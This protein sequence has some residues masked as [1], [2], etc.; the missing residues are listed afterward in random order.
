MKLKPKGV[1]FSFFTAP[2]RLAVADPLSGRLL[3]LTPPL[4]ACIIIV[5][6]IRSGVV[7]P[8]PGGGVVG[9]G[10]GGLQ[11]NLALATLL[12]QSLCFLASL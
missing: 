9:G 11:A 8:D 12:R 5:C 1:V 3:I 4:H 10:R 7:F 2:F 6:T